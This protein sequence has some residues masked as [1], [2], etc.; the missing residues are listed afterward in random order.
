[1]LKINSVSILQNSIRK[2]HRKNTLN[3]KGENTQYK[4]YEINK[5]QFYHFTR[6]IKRSHYGRS[7]CS[8]RLFQSPASYRGPFHR[9]FTAQKNTVALSSHCIFSLFVPHLHTLTSCVR[10]GYCIQPTA[11]FRYTPQAPLLSFSHWLSAAP[12]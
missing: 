12:C 10:R 9:H 8:V 2:S 1:M 4:S 5:Q 3:F 7:L 11:S 6:A